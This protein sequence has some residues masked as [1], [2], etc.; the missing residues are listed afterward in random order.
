VIDAFNIASSRP[1]AIEPEALR[2]ILLVADRMGDPEAVATRIGKPLENNRRVENRNGTAIIPI[3]GPLFRHA[4]LLTAISGA[5]SYDMLALD[6]QSALD[7]Q[8]VKRIVLDIDSP[9]GDVTGLQ[10]LANIIYS[11]RRKKDITAYI[12]GQGC[13]AAYWLASAAGTVIAAESAIV[14]SVGVVMSYTSTKARDEKEGVRKVEIVSSASPDK[15]ADATTEAGL[16]KYQAIVDELG[17]IFVREA[18][19]NRGVTEAKVLADFGK[20]FVMSGAQAVRA[21]MVDRLGSYE[22]VVAGATGYFPTSAA[23]AVLSANDGWDEATAKALAS[24]GRAPAAAP[25]TVEATHTDMWDK[26]FGLAPD[27]SP[28][29]RM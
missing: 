22:G 19:R 20:G 28:P 9:G 21:G 11:A 23:A 14:G 17:S 26:A 16:A 5:T 6:I 2:T 18:A 25:A 8:Y 13:S 1:W 27:S 10:E 29:D 4:N 15:R 24:L 3:S 7:N 12:G